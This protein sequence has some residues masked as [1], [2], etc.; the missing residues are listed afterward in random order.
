MARCGAKNGYRKDTSSKEIGLRG[1]NLYFIISSIVNII[2]GE[3]DGRSLWPLY[4]SDTFDFDK[5]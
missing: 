1:Q 5:I 2:M 4:V 3:W